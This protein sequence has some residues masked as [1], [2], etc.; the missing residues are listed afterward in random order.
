MRE[1]RRPGTSPSGRGGV[2]A[3]RSARPAPDRRTPRS[4]PAVESPAASSR[5][6]ASAPAAGPS[7]KAAEAK[8]AG[9]AR[10]VDRGAG[11]AASR[12]VEARVRTLFGLSTGR[13]LILAMM[14]CA[15]A[16]TLAVPLRTYFGQRAEAARAAALHQQLVT[17]IA[18]LKVKRS[19]QQDPAY[20]RAQARDRLRLVEP[21]ETP[22]I[23]QLPG[24]YQASLPP[25]QSSAAPSGPW[26]SQLWKNV[27]TPLPTPTPAPVT[28]APA[29]PP[30]PDAPQAPPGQVK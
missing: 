18:Q 21:G 2:D 6:P 4:S 17:D 3:R 14:T 9:A 25:V 30:P 5:R 8:P 13:A 24:E 26:Y 23:V 16:L 19:Q 7:R 27:S 29:A 22:Y 10:V 11:K 15:L 20:I 1:R 12:R 28:L